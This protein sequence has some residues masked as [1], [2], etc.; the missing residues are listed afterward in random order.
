MREND[1]PNY[2]IAWIEVSLVHT[3][4]WL[5]LSIMFGLFFWQGWFQSWIIFYIEHLISNLNWI[6]Y[7][8]SVMFF[9][10]AAL[11]DSSV[12]AYVSMG[13]YLFVATVL[14]TIEFNYG[15]SAIRYLD[16]DYYLDPK[17]LPSIFYLVG[18]TEHS[19]I[20]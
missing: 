1:Y 7:A 9:A 19:V 13:G 18:L 11:T 12:W 3:A 16:N 8:Q 17:L 20:T 10:S 15:T 5:P 14:Y 6:A 4:L 2:L